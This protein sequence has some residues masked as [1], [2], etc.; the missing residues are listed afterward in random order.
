MSKDGKQPELYTA[1]LPEL[2]EGWCWAYVGQLGEVVTG[3]TPS[4]QKPEYFG[5]EI[6]F[7]KPTDLNA[8]YYVRNFADSL[9][10]AG[11]MQA[12]L[13]PPLTILVTCIGATI[14][15]LGLARVRCA[16]NQQINAL[17]VPEKKVA[18][19]WAYWAFSSTWGQEQ[20]ISNASATTLPIL[21]KGKFERLLLP[22][23]PRNEQQRIVAKIEELF[24][25]LDAGVAALNRAKA[26]L[27]RYRA[28]VLKAAV[29]GKLTEEW[30]AKHPP[31]KTGSQLLERILKERRCRWESEQRAA[32]EKAGTQPPA[33][34]KTKYKEPAGPES[35]NLPALPEGWCWATVEQ[36]ICYLRN[37]LSQKPS[38]VP[39]GHRILRINA[40]RPMSVD[41]NEIRYYDRPT[42]D[43]GDYFVE[44]GDLLFTRY[45]GSVELLGVSG[46][47][48]GCSKPT[49]HPDKL[50]RV[51]TV[52]GHPVPSYL[53]IAS[54]VGVSRR[55]MQG[56]ARTT[57][58]QTGISGADIRQMPIPLCSL[59]EQTQIIAEVER[60]LSLVHEAESQ[61]DADL[62]RSTRLHQCILKRAFEG[63]L[64]PQDPKDEPANDL[65]ERIKMGK[66]DTNGSTKPRKT[67]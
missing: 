6:P 45:N 5:G 20:I 38:Q 58:G 21:N 11:A 40:V 16:T 66:A 22:V 29:E 42:E 31:T 65:L 34:W 12:R 13:L 63:K 56:R 30:R 64:V 14:G 48:R 55:H 54:N 39:P 51:R 26:K 7:F 4:K 67:T 43:V 17:I 8:G 35:N 1:S 60:R 19:E 47:V 44:D 18:P 62:K 57:A 61:I 41:L 25:D 46:M 3:S 27:K 49:L 37:G 10:E 50:I 28:A 33:N 24:Y 53:E 23:A 59:S 52:I 36:L 9:T 32:F 2:P 15:K